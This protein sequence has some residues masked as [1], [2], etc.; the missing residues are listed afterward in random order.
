MAVSRSQAFWGAV[1]LAAYVLLLVSPTDG[2]KHFTR[3]HG[4]HI[5]HRRQ[6]QIPQ[7]V[8]LGLNPAFYKESGPWGPWTP[9]STCSRTCGGGVA[10]QTRV[11]EDSR[12][13]KSHG[14]VGPSTRY[15]TC[16][17]EDCPDISKDFREEQCARFDSVPFKG[18]Y[19]SWLPYY[20]AGRPCELNCRPRGER[21]HYRHS[22]KTIDGTRCFDDGS[23]DVCVNGT[24][25][26]VGCD[27]MLGSDA[28]EDKCRVCQGDGSSC[29]P[30]QG[31]FDL[32]NLE[33]GYNDLL[34][35]PKGATNI[36]IYKLPT[37]N[38]LAV[39]NNTGHYYLNGNWRIQRP[40]SMV[41]AGTVFHYE[42]KNQ[43][44]IARESLVALGPTTETILIELLCREKNQGIEYEYAVPTGVS[45]PRPGSYKW[46][47]G[48]FGPCTKTCGEGLQSRLVY[49]TS[50]TTLNRVSDDL[51]NAT[52]K[53]EAT[54]VCHQKLCSVTWFVGEWEECSM[55]C[56]KGIQ[57]RVVLCLQ[58]TQIGSVLTEDSHCLESVGQKPERRQECSSGACPSWVAGTWSEC[59]R[60][61]GIGTQ[62]RDVQ[63]TNRIS[64]NVLGKDALIH[65]G[66]DEATKPPTNRTCELRPCDGLEW[67]TTPWS[68]CETPCSS[69]IE[70]RQVLCANDKGIPFPDEY[71]D[72]EKRPNTTRP[73]DEDDSAPGAQCQHKWYAS[74][75]SLCSTQCGR[76]MQTRQVFCGTVIDGSIHKT[77]DGN[78]D[79]ASKLDST[80]ECFVEE[81]CSGIWIAAPWNKCSTP[82][83]G[84]QRTRTVICHVKGKPA[85]SKNC[86]I[87]KKPFD[88][89]SCNMNA[90]DEDEVIFEAACKKSK[91]GCCPDGMTP[92]GANYEGCPNVTPVEG[93]CNAT[94]FG[95]CL[96]GVTPASGPFMK[97]CEKMSFCNGTQ[98]GCCPDNKT[99]AKG[100]NY[101]GCFSATAETASANCNTTE[102][103]C[104]PDGI[105][106]AA[107][108]SQTNC[109]VA[110]SAGVLSCAYSRFGCCSDKVTA[111]DGPGG[112]N[113]VDRSGKKKLCHV[114]T[115][116]CCPDGLSVAQGPNNEG[117]PDLF[118]I[119]PDTNCST[120]THGRCPDGITPALVPEGLDGDDIEGSGL[121]PP[122][123]DN[124]LFGRYPDGKTSAIGEDF[125]GGI[126]CT[127]STFGCCLDGVT[128]AIGEGFEGCVED[129]EATKY[130]CCP[131]MITAAGGPDYEGCGNCTNSLY[132][133]CEDN[134]TFSLGPRGEGCCVVSEFGCCRDNITAATDDGCLCSGTT[135][136]C[137]PDNVTIALGPDYEGCFCEHY[138]FGCCPDK[139]PADGPNF[140]GCVSCYNA[141]FGCCPGGLTAAL[142]PNFEGCNTKCTNTT[143]GCCPD[144]LQAANGEKFAGCS[145]ACKGTPFGCCPDGLAAASGPSFQGCDSC[146]ESLYGCCADNAS[147]AL[148]PD[149][150]GCCLYT[151]F[152][153]C[154]DN[155]TEARG[156]DLAGCSCHTTPHGCCPDGIAPARG[157]M[158]YGCTCHDY[159]HGCCQDRHTPAAGPNFEGCICSR[160]LYGCCPDNF[161]RAEGPHMAGCPCWSMEFGCCLDQRTPARG[162][163]LAG[164][165]CETTPYKCCPDQQT[166]ARGPG[167]HGCPCMTMPYGCC[168][169][170]HTAAKGPDGKGCECERLLYGCCADGRTPATGPNITGC[171][172]DRY[173][174]GCC[175]DGKTPARGPGYHGC[176]CTAM[177]YGCCDDT[178]TAAQGPDGQGCECERLL[179]GC[180]PDG[181]TPAT[182]ANFTGCTCNRYPHG[183]CPDGKTPARGPNSDGCTC[184]HTSYGCCSD[185]VTAAKG[186]HS[187]GCP[188]KEDIVPPRNASASV[189]DLPE[190][191]GPCRNYTVNW[192]FS[193][194]H[195][196]CNQFWYGGCEGNKN[197]FN[198][199]EECEKTCVKPEG[200]GACQL[201]KVVGPC[202]GQYEHWYFNASTRKCESFMYGG[203]L[204]NNNR[205]V[206]KDLCE[207]TCLHQETLVP[208]PRLTTTPATK[209]PSPHPTATPTTK[210]PPP[211]LTTTPTT[212]VPPPRLTTTPTTKVPPPRLTTTTTIKVPPPHL[213]T[214]TTIKVPPP[215]LTTTP[216][217][218]VPPPRLTTTT[219]IKVPPAH[220]T[221]TTTVKVPPPR[222]TMT[223][224]S[225]VP[226]PRLTTIL[227]MKD[228]CK[229]KADP[230]T[231]DK[232]I[233]RWFYDAKSLQ[234]Y[235]FT[236]A[237]DGGNKNRFKTSQKCLAFCSGITMDKAGHCPVAEAKALPVAT[238][239][240]E[241]RN[242]CRVDADCPGLRKCCYNGCAYTCAQAVST[243]SAPATIR[244][245]DKVVTVTV[246]E[247]ARLPCLA[248][249]YP[250]PSVSWYR[251]PMLLLRP[252]GRYSFQPDYTLVIRKVA[253]KDAGIYM[254]SAYNSHGPK[255]FWNVTLTVIPSEP[256]AHRSDPT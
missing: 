124:T 112:L 88:S 76:G 118:Q 230:G 51:C 85:A 231:G 222:H 64:G 81:F 120:S 207:Q 159:P 240:A 73:C 228:A 62:T 145:V 19:Y 108:S 22:P 205:F 67:V 158:Y 153:C 214:T 190:D 185:G 100:P 155:K 30:I 241:C 71:C 134:T 225:K 5:R 46:D 219:T 181:R 115:H 246:F 117:C 151:E 50:S 178:H 206:S 1:L 242:F 21:F 104:C 103:G 58:K 197:R 82:C 78:C 175:P 132:G 166:P 98:F 41:F 195:G 183:C 136:G 113:C 17:V 236:Y 138:P 70:T 196:R 182:G 91:H 193:V 77:S 35:I 86:D 38:N 142:G 48:D 252:R 141:T 99:A 137:C 68:G 128:A 233:R 10:Y 227:K 223:P 7:D 65:T 69:R 87:G 53:P 210:V 177:S 238:G 57:S 224:T 44:A 9:S 139:S 160:L 144:G 40:R 32:E 229:L 213:T 97:G 217:T 63:C 194:T 149:G 23:L 60:L 3:R 201:P 176:P 173:L 101:E 102:W 253:F 237:G 11:C 248:M 189:C 52:I 146:S 165:G 251:H 168:A 170:N 18:R 164:C 215:R 221:T 72:D 188:G 95:C 47:S 140:E 121:E 220:L 250:R 174:H 179:Y 130:G 28:V 184:T 2:R 247:T 109:A 218:K 20:K 4:H 212:E 162:P 93:G 6:H 126:N 13:D 61:C 119:P 8:A 232:R 45:R 152:G 208:P 36:K 94:E 12:A 243:A 90:C 74:E 56:G 14:C 34:E 116:G 239:E 80:R 15:F 211:R 172:C 92:S 129:C 198:S 256:A 135:H 154:Q 49:C 110:T 204:G 209:V 111:A 203:C 202:N 27:K 127:N 249:G 37:K 216:T 186:H 79:P 24:C 55:T 31:V 54:K 122:E 16:N 156:P 114:T 84:G 234:C 147:L 26:P 42:R 161:T 235:E 75:W 33:L 59:D 148:G 25:V 66:C 143:F 226:P 171:T 150:E 255:A 89:E 123:G 191:R 192:F 254:C 133:C 96:D 39:R 200:P 245:S 105:T 106:S 83:G 187:E 180:C 125:K 167:Y 131:D 163:N 169:D 29:K 157:P 244:P 199:Q 43:N 107:D